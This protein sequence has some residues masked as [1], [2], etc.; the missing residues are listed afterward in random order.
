[1]FLSERLK[2]NNNGTIGKDIIR[3]FDFERSIVQP[4]QLS[5]QKSGDSLSI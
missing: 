3:A 4:L 1:M 2:N 5:P